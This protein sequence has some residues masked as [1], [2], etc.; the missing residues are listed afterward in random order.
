M[1]LKDV[2]HNKR[3][4]VTGASGWIGQEFLC[5]LQASFGKLEHLDLDCTAS[6]QKTI[7]IHGEAIECKSLHSIID[8][9]PYDLIVHFAFALPN[10]SV[11][12]EVE[13]YIKI[14]MEITTLAKTLFDQNKNALKLIM[15]SGAAADGNNF[16]HSDLLRN[17]SLLKQNMESELRDSNSLV[18]RLWSATGHHLPLDSHYAL[19][20][21][22]TKARV[23]Q[24]ILIQNNVLRSYIYVSEMLEDALNYLYNGERGVRNSG[25][26]T[27]SLSE[28]AD[29]TVSTMNSKSRVIVEKRSHDTK[30]DYVSPESKIGSSNFEKF[31]SVEDQ[32]S[33]MIRNIYDS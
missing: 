32:I 33:K 15:S 28:L 22:I 12:I 1:S 9:P 13:E 29:L 2:L 4:L 30:F 23:N 3:I 19:A 14:N 8:S 5:Q 26:Y 25:G 18:A 10:P 7:S 20:D 6:K 24:D 27:V 11:A 17:Y 16:A 21:F 31:S